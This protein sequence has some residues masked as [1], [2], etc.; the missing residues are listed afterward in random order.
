MSNQLCFTHLLAGFENHQRSHLLS[1][2]LIRDADDRDITNSRVRRQGVLHLD[3]GD[4]LSTSD[5][6]VL[7]SVVDREVP[8]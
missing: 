7:D 4:V 8:V 5:D 1:P 6:D 2:L 3:G